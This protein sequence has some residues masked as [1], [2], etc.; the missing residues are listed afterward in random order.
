MTTAINTGNNT[1]R[2]S[3]QDAEAPE[4]GSVKKGVAGAGIASTGVS[5]AKGMLAAV[6][7]KVVAGAVAT[8]VN[9]TPVLTPPKVE[10]ASLAADFIL[11]LGLIMDRLESD[12]AYAA[13]AEQFFAQLESDSLTPA[14]TE[15]NAKSDAPAASGKL[16]DDFDINNMNSFSPV[17]LIMLLLH[18]L[19]TLRTAESA[20][21]A[22]MTINSA[23][24]VDRTVA[25]LEKQGHDQMVGAI[26]GTVIGAGFS[27]A[28]LGM[29]IK[30]SRDKYR[31]E[32]MNGTAIRDS[33]AETNKLDNALNST[34][35]GAAG[36][37]AAQVKAKA[38]GTDV[39]KTID[40]ADSNKTLV[41]ADKKIIGNKID[42]DQEAIISER[43]AAS[44]ANIHNAEKW[45]LG[46]SLLN[47][48]GT[49]ISGVSTAAAH[50]DVMAERGAQQHSELATQ[51]AKQSAN[52]AGERTQAETGKV[53]E[54]IQLLAQI[55][56]EITQGRR[57]QIQAMT[58]G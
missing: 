46:G 43:K 55:Q 6:E 4:T 30:S 23:A 8:Q 50:N 18:L 7:S 48:I 37:E 19:A 40:V 26:T 51:V 53:R 56:S 2:F 49:G 3:P 17:E 1:P 11:S 44:D 20:L 47:T 15:A 24:A 42:A 31:N 54:M 25:S 5:A 13:Q 39:D 38:S 16:H 10:L 34:K 9:D 29:N 14:A 28:S 12:P 45:G 32:K 36:T 21:N 58:R 52:E 35:P 27:V 22:K 33:K 41:D 57:A